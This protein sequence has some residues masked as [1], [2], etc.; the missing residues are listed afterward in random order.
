MSQA[1]PIKP[2]VLAINTGSSSLK[3][4]FFSADGVRRNLQY[5]FKGQSAKGDCR[6]AF[7]EL[8]SDFELLSD[9]EKEKPDIIA[10][11]FVHG[12]DILESAR[13]LDATELERLHSIIPLA[14][15][16]LP[17]SLLGVGLCES[18]FGAPQAACFDTAF[19]QTM[20]PLAKTLP[21]PNRENMHRY[22]FHGLS[23]AYLASQ[24]P[25]LIGQTAYKRVVMAHL[26]S[27]A[28]LCMAENLLST[29][30]TMGYTPAG[31]ICMATRSGD[32]DPGV[33]LELARR[34]DI[35]TLADMVNNQM[36]LLAISLGE[37]HKM[38]VLLKSKSPNAKLA[39]DYFCRQVAGAIG[40]LAAKTG[41]IDALVFS[42]G[43][44]EHSPHIRALICESLAF[45]GIKLDQ[46]AN[47][48]QSQ[49]LN[50][51]DSIPVLKIAT[52]EEAVM[53]SLVL[54]LLSTTK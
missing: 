37:S 16:H 24:L 40:S 2:S 42:G 46:T 6:T 32:I 4:S 39:I 13:L 45:M 17:M 30:T 43:I 35:D 22:G 49:H 36:G 44:G 31:G 25:S 27:G 12:G 7:S 14:P 51:S 53:H 9:L 54:S 47:L 5:H 26:G 10:H 38:E 11:R 41:G 23:Y 3:A 8:F 52:D 29:D 1:T 18:Y 50:A 28:S 48:E 21:I 19:H 15:L 20:S 34:H 33:M